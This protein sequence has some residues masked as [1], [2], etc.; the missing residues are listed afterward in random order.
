MGFW[1]GMF[2]SAKREQGEREQFGAQAL[3]MVRAQSAVAAADF[4]AEQFEIHYATH[5]G[6]RGRIDLTTAFRRCS[7]VSPREAA[8]ILFEFVT[9]GPE[10]GGT[11][12]TATGWDAV[13]P[14]LRPLIR[15][16][17]ELAV[18]VEGM[19]AGD[20]ML[21]RPIL[22]CLMESI[23]LDLPTSMQRV[24]PTM[25]ADWGVDAATV[26]AAARANMLTYAH[27]TVARYDPNAKD[28]ILHIPDTS[29]DR[30]AGSLP[31]VDGWLAGI[32][33]KAGARP[34][35]FVAEN[36]GVLVGAEY[37]ERHVQ[38]LVNA[39]R[40]LF[41]N[42]VRQVSPVPYTLDA[43][44]RLTPYQVP[45]NH[46]AWQEIR[47]AEA[48]LAANVYGQQY[49]TLRAELD[50]GTLDDYAAKLLHARK[51]DGIETT[52]T[53]WTDTVPTLLPRAHNVTLTNPTTGATFG[54]PWET[55]AA[56]I[57]LHPVEGL[58]PTRYRV[59]HH[60]A[61]PVMSTLRARAKMI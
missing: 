45:R 41:D 11:E 53:P 23:V 58:Y 50:E 32:G 33:A 21:W 27:D 25:L 15:P 49:E 48:T 14:N 5:S 56:A 2:G 13:A 10:L 17:G 51:P 24:H 7:K 35:V 43:T 9:L 54:V 18:R 29:G 40:E 44:G 30:Y 57:D 34:I 1:G 8:H 42:A 39:A 4:D 38:Y 12:E 3:A 47:S 37:S 16:A 36:V 55:L 20:H 28:G 26:F 46:L 19:R 31:L 52:I 22:P 61:E 6:I 59:E 60:P